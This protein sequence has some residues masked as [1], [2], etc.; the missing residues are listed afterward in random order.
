MALVHSY[1]HVDSVLWLELDR[2]ERHSLRNLPANRLLPALL[3]QMFSC[4]CGAEGALGA[5]IHLARLIGDPPTSGPSDP[6]STSHPHVF[7]TGS[8]RLHPAEQRVLQAYRD[9]NQLLG[10]RLRRLSSGAPLGQPLPLIAAT[11][12][13][14]NLNRHGFPG[15]RSGPMVRGVLTSLEGSG[16]GF[17]N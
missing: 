15:E 7:P 9:A 2:L 1:F 11:V 6:G 4:C 14:F 10:D 13:L 17:P 3:H 12:G 5:W 16:P 8:G